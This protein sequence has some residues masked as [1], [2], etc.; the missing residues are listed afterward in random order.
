MPSNVLATAGESERVTF[1]F[2]NCYVTV[3]PSRLGWSAG[4]A[5]AK[6]ILYNVSGSATSGSILGII[7]PSGAGK[8]TLLNL[9]SAT[10]TSSGEVRAAEVSLNGHAFSS[11]G[12]FPAHDPM[13]SHPWLITHG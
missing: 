7:G 3:I 9:L 8:T 1:D 5:S 13:A 12:E 10:P 2:R 11:S 6:T 4:E